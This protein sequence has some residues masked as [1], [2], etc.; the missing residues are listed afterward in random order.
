[1]LGHLA[2]AGFRI[3]TSGVPERR[4]IVQRLDV[5]TSGLMVV[6]K[7]ELAYTVLKRAFRSRERREDLPRAGAGPSRTRSPAPSTRRSAGIPGAD[8][9][10]AD[11][12]RRPAQRHPLRHP[13]TR[14]SAPRCSRS[15]WRPA[16]PIRSGSTWRPSTIPAW[17]IPMYGADPV[18]A[19]RLGL[20]R[21]WL[22]AVRLGFVHPAPGEQ[23]EFDSAYPG[24]LRT[25]WT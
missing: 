19:A 9:K 15:S 3:S 23:M 8:Y 2:G 14:S 12:R 21:Q 6:A 1:M 20:E 17:A 5:G 10:M 7:S 25:R 22:H 18:L 24:D 16:G 4:G 13:A 11:H